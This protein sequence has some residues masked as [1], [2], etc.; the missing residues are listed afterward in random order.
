[1]PSTK[2]CDAGAGSEAEALPRRSRRRV[3]AP[4]LRQTARGRDAAG[5]CRP[6]TRRRCRRRDVVAVAGA[7]V[8][9]RRCSR[10][11][12][13][14]AVDRS[15]SVGD[16]AVDRDRRCCRRRSTATA[17]LAA[18]VPSSINVTVTPLTAVPAVSAVTVIVR[19]AGV[20]A[21]GERVAVAAGVAG[22]QRF[23]AAARWPWRRSRYR[24]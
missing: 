24:R 1:M 23:G 18:I 8:D 4:R 13:L 7:A 22:R 11:R 14:M 21:A 3:R 6:A 2:S 10:S 20:A 15:S 5:Q 9:R 17:V 12:P 16:R 19:A